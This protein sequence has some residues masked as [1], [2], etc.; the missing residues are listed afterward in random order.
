VVIG[1]SSGIGR[2]LVGALARRGCTVVAAARDARDLDAVAADARARWD[3]TVVPLPLDL[4]AGDDA[5]DDWYAR[6]RAVLG[7]VDVVL[8]PAGV[9]TDADDG[10]V[11][12]ETVDE[13]VTTNFLAVMKLGNRFLT[14]FDERGRGTLALFSS[15]AAAAPRRRNVVYAAA[16]SAL[17]SYARSMQHRFADIPVHVQLY[18]LGYV[19]TTMSRGQRLLLPVASPA[20]VADAVVERLDRP[21]RAGYLP[22]YWGLVVRVLG[23]LPWFV[24]RRLAF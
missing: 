18:S 7:D 5:L 2:A 6:C 21:H 11:D 15:I 24:Y 23:H 3:A 9:V 8:V 17:E 12:W 10:I 19:D 22:R 20:R 14:H 4:L 16:K 13:L 1:G